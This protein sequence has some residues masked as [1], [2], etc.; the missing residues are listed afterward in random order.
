M[1]SGHGHTLTTVKKSCAYGYHSSLHEVGHNFGC[2]HDRDNG[3]NSHYDY[4]YGWLI[5]PEDLDGVGYRTVLAYNNPGYTRRVLQL[6]NPDVNYAGHA[7]GDR[8]LADN[9]RVIRDNRFIMQDI[10]DESE[11]C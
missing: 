2:H 1:T 6:S 3:D 11:A 7:T 8:D 10:G 9:A 5:G 4:G